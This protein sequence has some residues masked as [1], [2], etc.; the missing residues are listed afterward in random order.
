MRAAPVVVVREVHVTAPAADV[1][2]VHTDVARWP[3]WHPGVAF[4]SVSGEVAPGTILHLRLDG[5]AVYSRIEE[6]VSEERIAWR[7]RM[8][9]AQGLQRWSLEERGGHTTVRLEEA[10]GGWAPFLLRRTVRRSVERSRDA[11]LEALRRRAE[12]RSTGD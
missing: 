6:V 1:W 7:F 2:R 4:S 8:F 9:G 11:W 10:L 3:L 12:G 5:M